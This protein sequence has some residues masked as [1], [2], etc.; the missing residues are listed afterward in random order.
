MLALGTVAP[1]FSLP[2]VASGQTVTLA[3]F[4]EKKALL[5]MFVCAHCLTWCTC[6]Q[7]WPDWLATMRAKVWAS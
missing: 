5:V 6:S 4:T 2:D 7:N 3:D 1:D